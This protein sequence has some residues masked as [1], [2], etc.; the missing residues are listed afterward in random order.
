MC[1]NAR[2][3]NVC[4]F[5]HNFYSLPFVFFYALKVQFDAATN[6]STLWYS[7]TILILYGNAILCS[8]FLFDF[9]NKNSALALLILFC[10]R[11]FQLKKLLISLI[12]F[13]FKQFNRF[14][15]LYLLDLWR[16]YFV[17][18]I[19]WMVNCVYTITNDLWQTDDT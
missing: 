15:F 17:G 5:M 12:A 7:G 10:R 11:S 14:L 18:I 3:K 16:W 9:R 4:I 8:V 6:Q 1:V 13:F 2:N 19:M